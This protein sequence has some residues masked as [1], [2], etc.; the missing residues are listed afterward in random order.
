MFEIERAEEGRIMLRGR[1]DA[2]QSEKARAVLNTVLASCTLDF[3]ALDY[4]SSAGL[5]VL[6]G[7]Q[8]RLSASGQGLVLQ[9]MNQHVRE[10]FRIAGFD[11]VFEIR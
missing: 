7:A 8:R 5:G 2:A 1:L 3:G 6:L 4:I 9:N 11:Q 10:L